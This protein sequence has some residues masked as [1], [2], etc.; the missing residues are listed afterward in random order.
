MNAEIV[1]YF[2]QLQGSLTRDK[3]RLYNDRKEFDEQTDNAFMITND[4]NVWEIK[5]KFDEQVHELL[6]NKSTM[7]CKYKV[8]GVNVRLNENLEVLGSSCDTD[9]PVS[10]KHC[11]IMYSLLKGIKDSMPELP[12]ATKG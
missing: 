2:V 6:L 5:A 4:K 1:Q 12:V 9:K 7:V 8:P 11:M 10:L 3:P